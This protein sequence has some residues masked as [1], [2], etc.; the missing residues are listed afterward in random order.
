MPTL[1]KPERQRPAANAPTRSSGPFRKR[2]QSLRESDAIAQ[3]IQDEALK[4]FS[5][6][7]Y[8]GAS[9]ADIARA[10]SVSPALIHYYFKGKDILWRSAV[11]RGLGS[12]IDD[13]RQIMADLEGVDSVA[14]LKFFVRRFV[15]LLSERV[16]VIRSINREA[17]AGGERLQWLG[18]IY[19]KPVIGLLLSEV[20]A[21][22]SAGTFTREIPALNICQLIAGGCY[23][24][25][26]NGE[27]LHEM[28]GVELPASES[29]ELHTNY[30]VDAMFNGV[31]RRDRPS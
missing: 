18:E 16:T 13:L 28:F 4:L 21:A 30:L 2:G 1:T 3:G 19:F 22:Q 25:V 27:R 31:I 29:R 14:R 20:Q 12:T 7:G 9:I 26:L 24:F 10:S 6:R 11:S 17:D 23:H 8:D 15:A 5:V